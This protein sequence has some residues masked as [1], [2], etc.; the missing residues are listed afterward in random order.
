[1]RGSNVV[2]RR[3]KR[4]IELVTAIILLNFLLFLL[5]SSFTFLLLLLA[6]SPHSPHSL[7][8]LPWVLIY[9]MLI[10]QCAGGVSYQVREKIGKGSR[11]TNTCTCTC[12]S[13]G[14][15]HAKRGHTHIHTYSHIIQRSISPTK[16]KH[17]RHHLR[18]LFGLVS[19]LFPQVK[20]RV[21]FIHISGIFARRENKKGC[22]ASH[23]QS[24]AF[25][26]PRAT[27]DSCCEIHKKYS[28]L[29]CLPAG[30]ALR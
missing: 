25:H 2:R 16:K 1:M 11:A 29:P 24:H 13:S 22:H 27:S 28:P 30:T 14:C 17:Q 3:E 10:R 5:F 12:S 26:M 21:P 4:R 15:I 19:M 7:M 8:Y 9:D 18:T 6:V 20:S 23:L